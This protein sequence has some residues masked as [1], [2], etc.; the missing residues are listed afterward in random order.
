MRD[1]AVPLILKELS[2]R[3]HHWMPALREITGI[4]PSPEN[5]TFEEAI[6]AWLAWGREHEFLE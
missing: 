6:H 2:E 1:A 5:A 4:D 3:P